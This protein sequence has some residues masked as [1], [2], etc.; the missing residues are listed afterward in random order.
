M[1]PSCRQLFALPTNA[2]AAAISTLEPF[3]PQQVRADALP[4]DFTLP[5]ATGVWNV[6]G[7]ALKL[8]F[9]NLKALT[10]ITLAVWMPLHLLTNYLVY[11]MGQQENFALTYKIA[12]WQETM[13]GSLV[14][15]ALVYANLIFLRE[16]RKVGVSEAYR[17]GVKKWGRTFGA[18]FRTGL[19]V[20]VGV[21]LLVV[22]GIYFWTKFGLSDETA[23][24]ENNKV[25]A[26]DRS[27]DL[28]EGSRWR[29]LGLGVITLL[30]FFMGAVILS[31]PLELFETW[32]MA[33]ISEA[34]SS[35]LFGLFGCV[36]VVFYLDQVR[37]KREGEPAAG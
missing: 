34:V 33:A 17:W 23:A 3:A 30:A 7:Q 37:R 19:Y 15:P 22:P 27:E 31:V 29:F 5:I 24:I 21:I 32:W 10:F 25:S 6:M 8:F 26:L 13:F 2:N 9:R 11:A 1:C 14:S 12:M 16:G 36:F 20:G 18:R 4:L 35:V 28:T